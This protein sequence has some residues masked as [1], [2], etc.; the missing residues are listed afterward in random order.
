MQYKLGIMNVVDLTISLR[1]SFTMESIN[2][3]VSAA[4][5][6]IGGGLGLRGSRGDRETM[7]AGW[8]DD[9]VE[10]AP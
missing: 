10:T 8:S 6:M 2:F 9:T 1:K 5:G 7:L 4:T 3:T